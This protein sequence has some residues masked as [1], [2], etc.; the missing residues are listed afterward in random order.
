MT[1]KTE[2]NL[3]SEIAFS[4]AFLETSSASPDGVVCAFVGL[5]GLE[6]GNDGRFLFLLLGKILVEGEGIIFFLF[7]VATAAIRLFIFA[8]DLGRGGFLSGRCAPIATGVSVTEAS[9]VGVGVGFLGGIISGC[10]FY[11]ELCVAIITTPG[12]M[13]LLVR[14]AETER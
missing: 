6:F 13:D 4:V 8:V 2:I 3:A 11:F 14:V 7:L 12:L 5:A 1:R 9:P 10:F